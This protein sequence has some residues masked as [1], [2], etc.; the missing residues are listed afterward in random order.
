MSMRTEMKGYG[1]VG[2]R[3]MRANDDEHRSNR[4]TNAAFTAHTGWTPILGLSQLR[5]GAVRALDVRGGGHLAGSR[6]QDLA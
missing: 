1:Y 5:L 4:P 6:S 2:F 3:L